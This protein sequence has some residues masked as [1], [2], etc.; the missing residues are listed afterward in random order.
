MLSLVFKNELKLITAN[1]PGEP[2]L[3]LLL[4]A[5]AYEAPSDVGL[6]VG[7]KVLIHPQNTFPSSGHAQTVVPVGGSAHIVVTEREVGRD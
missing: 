7:Y 6:E 4:D 5:E 2:E 1:V 3:S